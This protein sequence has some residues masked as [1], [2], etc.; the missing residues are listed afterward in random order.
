MEADQRRGQTKIPERL[1]R[2]MDRDDLSRLVRD[3][4]DEGV[5]YQRMEDRA[6]AAGYSLSRSQFQKFAANSVKQTPSL[7]D[8]KA[9]AAGT[10]RPLRTVQRAAAVQ[11]LQYE[12][13]ELTGYGDDVRVIVAHLAGMGGD[14]VH[15]WR[16]MIEAD[17]KAQ[18]EAKRRREEE[19]ASLE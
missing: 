15:R 7:E 10:G 3:V 11:Y 9:I 17:E 19:E 8:L 6:R 4:N 13:T 12:A 2:S 16:A 14:D 18:Q 5:S 1:A